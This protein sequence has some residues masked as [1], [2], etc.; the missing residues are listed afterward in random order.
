MFYFEVGIIAYYDYLV[1]MNGI[2]S[3]MCLL[4]LCIG[5]SVD[6][7]QTPNVGVIFL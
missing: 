7:T 3:F 5:V 4:V 2:L 1:L 6:K